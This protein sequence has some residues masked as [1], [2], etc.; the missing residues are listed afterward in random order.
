M[1]G[2]HQHLPSAGERVQV[3]PP[4]DTSDAVVPRAGGPRP[5]AAND[6]HIDFLLFVRA[7]ARANAA[8][9]SRE[10]KAAND[11]DTRSDLRPL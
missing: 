2:D 7:F 9:D 1:K 10:W 8:R 5:T 11:N 6:A 4:S 3:E